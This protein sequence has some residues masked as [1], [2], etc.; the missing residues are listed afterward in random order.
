MLEWRDGQVTKLV[1]QRE[2]QE[3][4]EVVGHMLNRY[5]RSCLT[6]VRACSCSMGACH[7][8]FD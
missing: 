4:E 7:R 2:Y 3:F 8:S 1:V 6:Q 5:N